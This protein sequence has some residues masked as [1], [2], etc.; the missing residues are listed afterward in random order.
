MEGSDEIVIIQAED[1]IM[2]IQA[3]VEVAGRQMIALCWIP[4]S[5]WS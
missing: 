5:L 1:E 4:A 3:R 2:I